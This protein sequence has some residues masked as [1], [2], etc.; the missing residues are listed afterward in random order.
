MKNR[1]RFTYSVSI[2]FSALNKIF[3]YPVGY[4]IIHTPLPD[5]HPES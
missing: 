4:V 5:M 1:D 3:H 2:L